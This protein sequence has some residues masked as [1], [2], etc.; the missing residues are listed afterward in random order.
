MNPDVMQII[1][2]GVGLF[3]YIAIIVALGVGG[4]ALNTW[5]SLY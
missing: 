3:P 5:L 2:M 1:R 4:N